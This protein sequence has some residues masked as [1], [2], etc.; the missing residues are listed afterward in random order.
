MADG[1]DPGAA[2]EGGQRGPVALPAGGAVPAA[3]APG[4]MIRDPRL[5][6]F[7]AAHRQLA[8]GSALQT[9]AGF[10]RNAA[11]ESGSR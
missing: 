9:P 8:G 6:E 10:L 7:L 5:D 4:P 3:V 11:F 2:V 1:V